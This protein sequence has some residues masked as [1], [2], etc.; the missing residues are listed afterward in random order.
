MSD[1]F[2]IDNYKN[3]EED[4]KSLLSKNEQKLQE[5]LKQET[6]TYEN[7]VVPFELM[8]EELDI[9]ITPIFHLNSVKNSETTQKIYE[10]IIPH[11]SL[12]ST[13]LS[14]N[15]EV[16]NTFKTIQYNEKSSLNIEQQK[17]LENEIR[18]YE[19]S[20]CNLSDENKS[21]LE[22]INLKLSQIEQKFSQNLLDAT[23]S[24]EMICSKDEVDG[25]LPS[26][27]QS[28]KFIDE[29]N[30]EKYKF[31]LQMPSYL[32]YITYATNRSKREEIY[33]AYSTRAPQNGKLIEEILK[34]QDQK[35][36]ILGFKNYSQYSLATKMA[37]SEEEVIDF[38]YQI[39]NISKPRAKEELEEIKQLALEDNI[40][41]IQSYDIAYYSEKLKQE[42]YSIDEEF[43]KPYFELNSVLDGLFKV[44]DRLFKIQFKQID[45]TSWNDKVKVYNLL[46]QNNIIGKIYIDL[47][48]SKE[49]RGGA[50]MNNW[51]TRYK[52]ANK[53]QLP[54]AFVVCNFAQSKENI[55]SLLKHSDVVTLFHEMGHAL[56][57]LLSKVN[58]S[59]VSGIN[60]VAWDT[61]EFPS[62]FLEYFAYEKEILQMFAK[63][64][65]TNE[66][67]DDKSI[68]KLIQA[69][70]FQSALA[71][72]RQI[73]FALFDFKLY[74]KVLKEQ[75]VQ[76]LLDEVRD[77]IAVIKPPKYNKFQNGFAHI[78]AGGYSAGYYSYKW[79]EVLSADAFYLFKEN[80]ILNKELALSYKENILS[81]GGSID[82]NSLYFSFAN[83]K[84]KV[85]SLLKIDGIL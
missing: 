63:H 60:G 46:E 4:L 18:D 21:S 35:V 38:L 74:Q 48:V 22:E 72:L 25:L 67:L 32:A 2:N 53:S 13:R 84:P 33:K 78:F 52:F 3:I 29:N 56:H 10:T 45:E 73:E 66:V 26:D 17:V 6:K 68:D 71:T 36:K 20:G 54:T 42:K 62:Q 30:K 55:P 80:G 58:E 34:L 44:L 11:L 16:Y 77:E 40:T 39:A 79:A 8:S 15:V 19:L 81:K 70:N 14:Q 1:I 9:F 51:H 85:E 7:F 57:H 43:Y 49:K 83:R 82:M 50:W 23:N 64:Y 61:V 12:Y 47:E 59:F 76:K 37:N 69:R 27:L 65:K 24:W 31:T 75:G 41:D 5:L 28:A